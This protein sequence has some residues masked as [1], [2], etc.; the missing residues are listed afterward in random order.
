VKRLLA[1][2]VLILV[3]VFPSRGRAQA[4]VRTAFALIVTNNH[5]PQL[6]RPELQY[7]DDDGAKY[8]ETFRT[9]APEDHV[10]LLT[11]F[12]ADS[13]RL[14]PRAKAKAQSATRASVLAAGA[15]IAAAVEAE[16]RAGHLVDFYFVFAGHGDVE[17][18]RGFLELRDARFTSSD[19][20][21]LLRS[22]PA[23]R[24]HVIL[25]SCNSFFVLSPRK[26]GGRQ[27]VVTEQVAQSIGERLPNVGV[28][29]STSAEAEVYEWSELQ[30]GIFSHAVRS[31]LA[32]AAD[33]DHDGRVSYEELKAF[34]E[35]SSAQV[36]NP[37][38]R[39]KVFAR[40][41]G[42]RQQ[43]TIFDL[44]RAS[45]ARVELDASR[46]ERLTVRDPN[47]LRWIDV[48]KEAGA[49]MTLVVPFADGGAIDVRDPETG[50]R[51][52]RRILPTA[53]AE[54]PAALAALEKNELP[55]VARGP[56]EV[57]AGLFAKA[58]GP[59]ALAEWR[60]RA[61]TEPEAVFGASRDEEERMRLLL[62]QLAATER[63]ARI[64]WGILL[65][66]FGLGYAAVGSG[67]IL[68]SGGQ[69][70][71]VGTFGVGALF[72]MGAL[73]LGLGI[74][75]FVVRSPGERLYD[76]YVL[77]MKAPGADRSRILGEAESK[78]IA[79]AD[80]ERKRRQFA[81]AFGGIAFVL[82]GGVLVLNEIPQPAN[83]RPDVDRWPLRVLAGTLALESAGFFLAALFPSSEERLRDLWLKDPDRRRTSPL[84]LSFG[85][86]GVRG[87]F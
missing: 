65:S 52:E 11:D 51:T 62:E 3:L 27:I 83:P 14:F 55:L 58:F 25:D 8:Y 5:S 7:A 72:G 53:R 16:S 9:L 79:R 56:D 69:L 85:P 35:V 28:L 66:A 76:D 68:S 17:E 30:S 37:L 38:Y 78:I 22:I 77:R 31:G 87:S 18:G 59:R 12:D 24:S 42:G 34:I 15:R 6:G 1:L 48:H 50:M 84:S 80:A 57:L 73:M 13:A 75:D 82:A 10:E 41:P 45:G 61:R 26:P 46:A 36:A 29:L 20:E 63:G 47:E 19:V 81:R 60:E 71:T 70:D 67:I 23:T 4:S 43:E 40:G 32:G 49:A 86:G 33:A 54:Q 64:Q 44:N 39:P 21:G 74:G 2:A